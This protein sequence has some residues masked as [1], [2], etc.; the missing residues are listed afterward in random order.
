MGVSRHCPNFFWVPP[1][2]SRTSKATDFKFGG[3]IYR[4]NPNKSSL[5]ILDKGERG[6]NQGVPKIF[7]APMY[8]VHCAIIFAIAQLSCCMKPM[9]SM[10]IIQS[11]YYAVIWWLKARINCTNL[12]ITNSRLQIR[13]VLLQSNILSI[14][15]KTKATRVVYFLVYFSG[16]ASMPRVSVSVGLE[17]P[18][19]SYAWLAP[20]IW[21]MPGCTDQ[22]C[23][24]WHA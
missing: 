4:A 20:A 5:K 22:A 18:C 24:A 15:C 9:L 10:Y 7:R 6:R 3:Y 2:I 13:K 19:W 17:R 23:H 11:P 8:K 12:Y 16:F 21:A 1:I 14:Y